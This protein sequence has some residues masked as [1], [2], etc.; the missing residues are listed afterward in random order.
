MKYN[1]LQRSLWRYA[2]NDEFTLARMQV[3]V[4]MC[5]K[6]MQVIFYLQIH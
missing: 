4:S 2:G 6:P 3:L 5:S 1:V